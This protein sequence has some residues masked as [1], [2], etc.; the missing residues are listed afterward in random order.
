MTIKLWDWD[1]SWKCTLF[2]ALPLL[3]VL[4]RDVC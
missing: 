4:R 2:L 3:A 1:K